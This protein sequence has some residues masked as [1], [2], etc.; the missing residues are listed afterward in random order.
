VC[1]RACT[2]IPFSFPQ[3]HVP[4][5]LCEF[6]ELVYLFRW[7]RLFQVL[8]NLS[9]NLGEPVPAAVV[10]AEVTDGCETSPS[11]R[12]LR[13]SLSLRRTPEQRD[14][15]RETLREQA[16]QGENCHVQ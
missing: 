16:Q 7:Y 4:P 9:G 15:R 14:S 8:G 12:P 5:A 13:R 3:P 6:L 1:V 2:F 10:A 11:S